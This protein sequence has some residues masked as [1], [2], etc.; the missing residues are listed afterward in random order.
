MTGLKRGDIVRWHDW[1]ALRMHFRVM[2]RERGGF[3]VTPTTRTGRD[4]HPGVTYFARRRCLVLVTKR[5]DRDGLE[6][7]ATEPRS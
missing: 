4:T 1:T 6:R 2:R 5:A 7:R 3:R